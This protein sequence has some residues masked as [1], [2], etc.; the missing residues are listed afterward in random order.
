MSA[1]DPKLPLGFI[2]LSRIAPLCLQLYI[3]LSLFRMA[4]ENMVSSTRMTLLV[5]TTK[6]AFLISDDNDR[7]GWVI[8]G[9]YCDGW[10]INHVIGD[11]ETGVIWAGGGGEWHG[12]GIWCSEDGGTSW[13]VTRLTK[14]KMDDWAA[15]DPNFAKMIGWTDEPL[16]FTDAF[17]QIWSLGYAHG[18]LYAGTKPANL[19]ASENGGK[20]WNR[21]QALTDH[22]SANSWNPG[23]LGWC[24]TP[25]CLIQATRKS[26]GLE[27]LRPASS[28]PRTA[29]RPG[30]AATA[31][32][33]S[34]HV[35]TTTTLPRHATVRSDTAFTTWYVRRVQATCFTSRTTMVYG[36]R[37]TAAEAGTT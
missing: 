18:T 8:Q 24:C 36:A 10:P 37:P 22:P 26:S 21:I 35:V 5:G 16:P 4:S 15:N 34:K 29:E 33:T 19:L 25:S 31:S 12:A 20:D 7:R 11:P 1:N 13:K 9:P 28:L 6:G 3:A 27:S 23:A 30:S 14:G 17:A 32:R 2:A